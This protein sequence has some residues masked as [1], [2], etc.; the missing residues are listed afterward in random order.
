VHFH[1]EK[2]GGYTELSV[3]DDL[4]NS[5]PQEDTTYGPSAQYNNMMAAVNPDSQDRDRA[6]LKARDIDVGIP[7]L[8]KDYTP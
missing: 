3:T 8:A 1:L 5:Y 6:N 4:L 7:I 2:S